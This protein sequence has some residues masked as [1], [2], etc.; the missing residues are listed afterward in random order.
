MELLRRL[1]PENARVASEDAPAWLEFV[2]L[3][4]AHPIALVGPT[5]PGAKP[6]PEETWL[7]AERESWR[8][9]VVGYQSERLL[10]V[11]AG[12]APDAVART[13]RAGE[14]VCDV[15]ESVFGGTPRD[16][17]RL[18][19]LLY[20]T[21]AEYLEHSGSDLGGIE[22]VLDST[23]GHFDVTDQVSRLFLTDGEESDARLLATSTH[24]LTHHWLSARSTL[25]PPRSAPSAPGFWVVE[26]I[27]TWAEELRLDPEHD[28]WRTAPERAASLD[29]LVHARAR[30]LLPWRTFLALSFD[31]YKK[32]ETR[33][34]CEL[35]LDWHLGTRAPRSPMQLFYAQGAA[36]AHYLYEAEDGARRKLLL[37]AVEAYYRGTQ[38]DVAVR[39][40]VT[41]DELGQRVTAWVRSVWGAGAERVR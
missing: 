32:L 37:Q 19:L 7:A 34:T 27:A 22:A 38:L 41:P 5:S 9:D 31:D 33:P 23:S 1:V 15:L 24:E 30:D 13:V 16:A 40:G 6:T 29:A 39:M 10:V 3:S 12:A 8:A 14:L 36:L 35:E 17:R 25:G 21:R 26:A 20:P 4:A 11:T 2:A 28:T 18:E